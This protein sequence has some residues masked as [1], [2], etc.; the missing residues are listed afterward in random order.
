MRG[1]ERHLRRVAFVAALVVAVSISAIAIALGVARTSGSA[2]PAGVDVVEISSLDRGGARQILFR[3]AIPDGSFGK[4]AIAMLAHPDRRRRVADLRCDRVDFARGRGICLTWTQPFGG[5]PVARIFDAQL[6]V[7]DQIDLQGIPSRAR[8]S[9][10]GRL[11]ATT[12][13][14]R[15]DSYAPGKFSTRTNI[16][17]MASG[18]VLAHLEDFRIFRDGKR[19]SNRNF[20]FW[21]VTFE[22]DGDHFYVTLGSGGAT[23]LVRGSLRERQGVVVHPRV[24]CPSLSPDGTRI[25]YKKT[26]ESGGRWRLTVLDLRTMREVPL[27]ETQSVDDQVEWLDDERVAYWRGTDVWT[28]PADGSGAPQPFIR[29]ASSPAVLVG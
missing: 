17:E 15:G 19:F 18:R 2:A 28:V 23:Y 29:S 25:A 21:G 1:R 22:G 24:E 14:V 7:R 16:V 27:A 20:N 9:R 11:A 4:V 8:I 13:F 26:L 6:R 10:D 3:N 5:K 12:V